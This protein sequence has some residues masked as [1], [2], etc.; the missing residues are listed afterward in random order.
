MNPSPLQRLARSV[1]RDSDSASAEAETSAQPW[2]LAHDLPPALPASRLL[3]CAAGFHHHERAARELA[4]GLR[5][6]LGLSAAQMTVLRPADA[7]PARYR[8]LARRWA[9]QPAPA[10]ASSTPGRAWATAL[11]AV[12]GVGMP[13]LLVAGGALPAADGAADLALGLGRLA[14][15]CLAALLAGALLFGWGLTAACALRRPPGQRFDRALQRAL[16]RGDWAV[17]VHDLP[18]ALH[19]DVATAL[20]HNSRCWCAQAPRRPA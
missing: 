3:R 16:R 2:A 17:V 8:T 14:W 9:C 6:D 5:H 4:H 19:A 7:D 10:A 1:R 13:S 20:R 11:L 18:A 12:L 15:Q